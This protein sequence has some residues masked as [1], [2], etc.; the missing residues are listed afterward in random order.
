MKDN[1]TKT[2]WFIFGTYLL[3]ISATLLIG[4]VLLQNNNTLKNVF[5]SFFEVA[6]NRTF[7]YRQ[8]IKVNKTN[9]Q[10]YAQKAAP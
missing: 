7:D 5:K 4:F 6:E 10:G 3:L 2:K 8:S 9:N 1:L